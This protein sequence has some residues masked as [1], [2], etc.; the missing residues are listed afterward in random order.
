MKT[1]MLL[2]VGTALM[3]FVYGS[4]CIIGPDEDPNPEPR[5]NQ[6]SVSQ[7]RALDHSSS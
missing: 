7:S 2:L 6:S 5:N 4:G 3:S 1:I